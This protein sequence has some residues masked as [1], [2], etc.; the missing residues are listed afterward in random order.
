MILCTTIF[1]NNKHINVFQFNGVKKYIEF[2][3]Y[4]D[5]IDLNLNIQ[6]ID[7]IFYQN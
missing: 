2:S 5:E 3:A 6:Q 1:N 4:Y 7:S